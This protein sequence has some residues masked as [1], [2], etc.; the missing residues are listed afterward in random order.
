EDGDS[1]WHLSTL[2]RTSSESLLLRFVLIFLFVVVVLRSEYDPSIPR[3]AASL[4]V[5]IR[6]REVDIAVKQQ[7]LLRGESEM[8]EEEEEEN[9]P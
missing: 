4:V 5:V 2:S 9:Q 3:S 8:E 7:S 1:P 6:F